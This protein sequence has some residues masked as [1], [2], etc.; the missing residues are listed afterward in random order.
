VI[1]G[2][3]GLG[4]ATAR[5]AREAS[6]RVTIVGRDPDRL[7]AAAARLGDVETASADVADANDV[8]RLFSA[9]GPVDHIVVTAGDVLRGGIKA[10]DLADAHR[11][12]ESRY[13]GPIHVARSATISP[14]GSLTLVSGT[15]GR[16]PIAHSSM[17]FA[18]VGAV[19][20][21]TRALAVELAP[22]RVNAICPGFM[23]TERTVKSHGSEEA[24]DKIAEKYAAETPVKRAGR[25][26]DGARAILSLATN[27]YITGA[28]LL[29]DG[30]RM[31]VAP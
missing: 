1:G 29:I 14:G 20:P 3:S 16:R 17:M 8:E 7:G 11:F 24:A 30:G 19:E 27:P 12:T 15:A 18:V 2:S 9:L 28:V 26:E 4:E 10:V 31:L 22:V 25:P 21:L 6:A 23:R 5:L 13:W